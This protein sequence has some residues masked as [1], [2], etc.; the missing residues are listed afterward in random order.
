MSSSS[1]VAIASRV[2]LSR[3]RIDRIF[4]FLSACLLLLIAVIGFQ[5]FYLHGRAS[6]GGPVLQTIVPLV[7][8]HGVAMS[9][10]IVLFVVQSSLIVSGN[11][12]LHMSLGVAGALL[13]RIKDCP[14]GCSL[15]GGK[16]FEVVSPRGQL[17]LRLVCISGR[18]S[19]CFVGGCRIDHS[20]RFR[21]LQPRWLQ[22]SMGSSPLPEPH[23]DQHPGFRDSGWNRAQ[24]SPSARDP[25]ADDV[26]SHVICGWPGGLIPNPSH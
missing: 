21:P 11:R 5:Q 22:A 25:P 26:S 3:E 4:Y 17:A 10:W 13:A 1:A 15:Y 20:D 8:L 12:K 19:S 7:I 16:V 23:V 18:Q 14:A 24:I 9:S 6:D 2:P